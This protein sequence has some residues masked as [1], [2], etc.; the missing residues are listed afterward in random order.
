MKFLLY[1]APDQHQPLRKQ[2]RA[3]ATSVRRL[4]PLSLYDIIGVGDTAG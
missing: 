1:T 3:K 2:S 4:V